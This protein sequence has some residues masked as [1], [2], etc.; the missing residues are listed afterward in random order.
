[1]KFGNAVF[2]W[3]SDAKELVEE[4]YDF[5]MPMN[6]IRFQGD[7]IVAELGTGSVVPAAERCRSGA[8]YDNR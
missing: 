6:T 2:V 1:M 4:Y 8:A 5:N 3:N 7:L